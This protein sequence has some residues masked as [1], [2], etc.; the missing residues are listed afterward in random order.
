MIVT[1]EKVIFLTSQKRG[2]LLEVLNEKVSEKQVPVEILIRA[3]DGS[4]QDELFSQ[5]ISIIKQSRDGKKYGIPIK[6][7]YSGPLYEGFNEKLKGELAPVDISRGLAHVFVTKDEEEIKNVKTASKISTVVMKDYLVDEILSII[8]EEKEIKHSD[9]A[10]KVEDFIFNENRKIKFPSDVDEEFI[11][12]CYSPIIQSKNYNLK[13]SAIS[14]DDILD[15]GIIMCSLGTRYH[16]Y[17]SNIGRTFLIDPSSEQEANYEFLLEL[18]RYILSTIRDGVLLKDVYQKGVD[19]VKNKRPDLVDKLVKNFGFSMGIEF[20]ESDFTINQKNYNELSSNMVLNLSVGFQDIDGKYSLMLIDTVKVTATEPIILTEMAKRLKDISFVTKEEKEEEVKEVKKE[21]TARNVVLKTKLRTEDA[22]ESSEATRR[23]HQKQLQEKRH[24]EMMERFKSGKDNKVVTSAV[25]QKHESYRKDTLLPREVK[26]LQIF[27][28]KRSDSVIFPIYG[29]AVPFHISCIKN[30]SKNDEGDF[31]YLRVNLNSPG[32]SFGK[33][34]N[35]PH[36]DPNAH[37][38]RALTFK[39][40]DTERM[41]RI[42]KE[43]TDLK[44][45]NVKQE[46]EKKEMADLVEQD[47]LIEIKGNEKRNELL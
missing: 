19:Y 30:V 41:N 8:D 5:L 26:N 37:F 17:C 24:T 47:K 15:F 1:L 9:L 3:K 40:T 4:N 31:V 38:I 12:I 14:T 23:E 22:E 28:D 27:V 29:L 13:P 16:S 10:Q 45:Q 36:E 33:K 44:K 34:D 2:T 39:S 6:D 35:L 18:Q 46:A 42:F 25:T 7:S 11:D 20:K 21:T 43:I 32:Q